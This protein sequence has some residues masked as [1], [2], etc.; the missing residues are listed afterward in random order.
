[1]TTLESLRTQYDEQAATF[2]TM[3]EGIE[4]I[5]NRIGCDRAVVTKSLGD[6]DS[7]N[8]HNVLDHLA[9]VER[10]ANRLLNEYVRSQVT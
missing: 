6:H 3:C 7:V 9:A 10:Q 8:P 5:F 2:A 1:M 4:Q